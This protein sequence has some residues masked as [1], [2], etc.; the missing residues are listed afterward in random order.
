[1]RSRITIPAMGVSLVS[2]KFVRLVISSFVTLT[3]STLLP[4]FISD[5]SA[6]GISS[7]NTFS[8]APITSVPPSLKVIAAHFLSEENETLEYTVQ[9]LLSLKYSFSA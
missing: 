8:G 2:D 3:T 5:F 9:A 7:C 6:S 1:M 4:L